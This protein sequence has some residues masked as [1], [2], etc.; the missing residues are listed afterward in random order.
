MFIRLAYTMNA[1]ECMYCT[2]WCRNLCSR[3]NCWPFASVLQKYIQKVRRS[4]RDM[5]AGEGKATVIGTLK[6]MGSRFHIHIY[7]FS[8]LRTNL[9]S[10]SW[11]LRRGR[12]KLRRRTRMRTAATTEGTIPTGRGRGSGDAGWMAPSTGFRS[13][14]TPGF[15]KCWRS[16]TPCPCRGS[17]W[18]LDSRK[19]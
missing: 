9:R 19:R 1:M 12:R 7:F 2:S 6:E 14:S 15:G 4:S 3:G 11:L 5:V 13:D 16:A 18:N 8:L 17:C 10:P